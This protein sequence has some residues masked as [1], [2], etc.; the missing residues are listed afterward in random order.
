[1][2]LIKSYLNMIDLCKRFILLLNSFSSHFSGLFLLFLLNMEICGLGSSL[3]SFVFLCISHTHVIF[4]L[5]MVNVS[6]EKLKVGNGSYLLGI[7]H[8]SLAPTDGLMWS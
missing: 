1:M 6:Y 5:Y 4:M 7:L 2:L 3:N 8:S